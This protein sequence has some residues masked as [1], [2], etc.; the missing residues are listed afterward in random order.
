MTVPPVRAGSD[1]R[2]RAGSDDPVRAGADDPVRAMLEARRI[3]VV[4]ASGRP[5]SFGHRL[6]TEVAASASPV[7]LH[8]V[9][10]RYEEVLGRPCLPSL[11]AIE[12]PVDVVLL[13]VAD[14]SVE[15]QLERAA[16][17]GDRAAVIYGSLFD[18]PSTP[19]PSRRERV[20]RMA[21][22]AGMAVCGGGCMGFVNVAAGIR[23]I[24]YVEPS[25]LPHGPVAFITHSG[26]V[27][28]ALL[29]TRRRCRSKRSAW[30]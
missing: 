28:S 25:D 15:G 17:R 16:R 21:R 26:S 5:G 7:D 24:G 29:R 13:A 27:F 22:G 14:G 9:N 4:G 3:A 19:G 6:V 10:P 23:A 8:L 2:V 1:D 20:A 11:D 12:G 30:R 18:T